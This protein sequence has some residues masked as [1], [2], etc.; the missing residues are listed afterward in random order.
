MVLRGKI[1]KIC[2]KFTTTN[3]SNFYKLSSGADFVSL[4]LYYYS[5]CRFLIGNLIKP[6]E[7]RTEEDSFDI[8]TICQN[9]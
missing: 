4:L 8:R 6:T 5:K 1:L 9:L 2:F 7:A 3:N